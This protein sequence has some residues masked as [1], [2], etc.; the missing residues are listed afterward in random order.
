MPRDA[1]AWLAARG[2]RREPVVGPAAPAAPDA[3]PLAATSGPDVPAA[4][5]MTA[6]APAGTAAAPSVRE[7]LALARQAQDDRADGRSSVPDDQ[8]ALRQAVALLRRSASAAPQS[9]GRLRG[10]LADRGIDGDVA[11]AAIR[12]VRSEGLVDDAA[13][14]AA[15]VAERRAKGHTSSRLRHDLLARGFAPAEVELA[16]RATAPTD[17][18][19]EAFAEAV[20]LAAGQRAVTAETAYRRVV[21]RL[22]RLGHPEAT[23]RKV[24]R[25][26]VFADREEQRVTER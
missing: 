13:M 20:R 16:V 1:E 4:A 17:P 26:A 15:L 19:A 23:A 10:K 8:E 5:G 24:A 22:V 21:G 9:E 12:Q 3:T 18:E 11:D 7:V 2:V 25:T 6:A 14:L